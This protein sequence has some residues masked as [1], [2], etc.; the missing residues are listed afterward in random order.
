MVAHLLAPTAAEQ[1]ARSVLSVIESQ[2]AQLA[3]QNLA[4]APITTTRAGGPAVSVPVKRSFACAAPDDMSAR[5]VKRICAD[6]MHQEGAAGAHHP[7][8]LCT[9]ARTYKHA[10][11][12]LV[13]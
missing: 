12:C 2:S 7:S 5:P 6:A 9:L 1:R 3:P 4:F 11:L 13:T 10:P 8:H